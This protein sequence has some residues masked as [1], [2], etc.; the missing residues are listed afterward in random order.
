MIRENNK[1]GEK[2]EVLMYIEKGRWK[3]ITHKRETQELR[4]KKDQ[5]GAELKRKAENGK[6]LYEQGRC[7][8]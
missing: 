5:A 8:Q 4:I 2:I 7:E 3:R 1:R 6:S